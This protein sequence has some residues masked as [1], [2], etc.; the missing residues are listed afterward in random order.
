MLMR[1]AANLTRTCVLIVA[2]V[3]V[4]G[5]TLAGAATSIQKISYQSAVT[6][7]SDGSAAEQAFIF[8]VWQGQGPDPLADRTGASQNAESSY[9][10][11]G[12]RT[13]GVAGSTA[14]APAWDRWCHLHRLE[15]PQAA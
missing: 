11:R 4:S 5:A 8:T 15:H 13:E 12:A 1:L 7:L 10:P 3:A 14:V 9:R 2:L 6:T